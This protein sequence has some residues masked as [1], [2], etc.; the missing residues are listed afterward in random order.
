MILDRKCVV[1]TGAASGIGEALAGRFAAEGAHLVIADVQ[2]DALRTVARPIE[3][4]PVRCDVSDESELAAL[5]DAAEQ[6][7]GPI[8]LFCSNAGIIVPGGAAA[9]LRSQSRSLAAAPPGTMMPA[10][11]QNRSIGP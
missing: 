4:F 9:R 6:R 3:A 8:D 7:Y 5:V 1:V 10:F 11:E 2:E